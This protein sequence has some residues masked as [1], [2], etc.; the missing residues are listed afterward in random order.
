MTL[1]ARLLIVLA[2]LALATIVANGYS[3]FMFSRLGGTAVSNLQ[4][5]KQWSRA[6]YL[7]AG[8]NRHF[9]SQMQEWKNLLLR[10]ADPGMREQHLRAVNSEA[11]EV[12]RHLDELKQLAPRIG[13][14][15]EPIDNLSQSHAALTARYSDALRQ[16]DG[17]RF[18][19]QAIDRVVEG[20]GS[21][22]GESSVGDSIIALRK[23]IDTQ[24]GER[25]DE[26]IARTGQMVSTAGWSMAGIVLVS[27]VA[28]LLA[29]L[30]FARA[31][32]ALLGGEPQYAAQVVK[33]VA[34]GDLAFEVKTRTGDDESLLA[35]IAGMQ[36]RLREMVT[37][38]RG[39]ADG[40]RD[41]A[42][43]FAGMTASI[44][45]SSAAQSEAAAGTASAVEEM[46]A[47]IHQ[48]AESAATVD[49]QSAASLEKTREG[50][51]SL[52]SMIGELDEVKSAVGDVALAAEAFIGSAQAIMAMTRQVRDIA[53]QTNLLALNAAIEAAR[54][55]EQGRGF[56]VV[57]DEVRKLAE[58]SAV[59]AAEI[60]KVT[61][62]L[63]DK[64]TKV[65][66]A[67]GHG[68]SALA[69]SE[70]YLNRMGEV[71]A[72][73][74]GEVAHTRAGMGD[75]SSSVRSQTT[76]SN[77]IARNIERIA[78]MAQENSGAVGQAAGQARRL[79][80]LAGNLAEVAGRFSV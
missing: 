65:E 71:L 14:A 11:A 45:A 61:Q 51:E 6:V 7:G 63:A 58:K 75:I 52:S 9:L 38:I 49:R 19:G 56:A 20:E 32:L 1:R 8:A 10:G 30:L 25:T 42:A 79:E 68:K 62:S 54:A 37:Q 57:A 13:L 66:G 74:N 29:C 64:S 24:S 41:S 4:E 76:A 50:N 23:V 2:V 53:D 5:T 31:L 46:S 60:D 80:E 40:L 77:D 39:A 28:G 70:A 3:L 67:I 12:R 21:Q 15:P 69:S 35:A 18:N 27:S 22:A 44:S 47:S 59:A 78:R 33:R 72:V 26:A 43:Q 55:G 34:T 36:L 17:T 73:A 16:F 48:V